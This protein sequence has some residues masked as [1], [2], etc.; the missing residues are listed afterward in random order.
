MRTVELIFDNSNHYLS[1]NLNDVSGMNFEN[2]RIA[3]DFCDKFGIKYQ[4]GSLDLE[5]V[6]SFCETEENEK[7]TALVLQSSR[8]LDASEGFDVLSNIGYD[9]SKD[10]VSYISDLHLMHKLAHFE[11]KSKDDVDFVIQ[12]IVSNIAEETGNILLLG[13]D[14]SSD[15]TI[16][17]MFVRLLRR[18]LDR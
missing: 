14:I 7:N 17:E 1:I 3:S 15:F 12:T 2:A 5:K 4:S 16:F 10:R 9:F 6:E 11:P 18:E 8:E 13:G